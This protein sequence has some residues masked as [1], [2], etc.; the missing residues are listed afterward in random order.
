MIFTSDND[1]FLWFG[2]TLKITSK[3]ENGMYVVQIQTM[4]KNKPILFSLGNVIDF[5]KIFLSLHFI[6]NEFLP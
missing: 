4:Q 2:L 3:S 1:V 5:C 6:S